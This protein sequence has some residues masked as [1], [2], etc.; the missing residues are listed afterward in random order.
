[1]WLL[2]G[3]FVASAGLFGTEGEV[4]QSL[5]FVLLGTTYLLYGAI[6]ALPTNRRRAVLGLRVASTLLAFT[7]GLCGILAISTDASSPLV[8]ILLALLTV[9]FFI[10]LYHSRY[11]TRRS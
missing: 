1:P 5:M 3:S 9:L 6:Y 2:C 8:P 11:R 7:A 10:Y 4:L